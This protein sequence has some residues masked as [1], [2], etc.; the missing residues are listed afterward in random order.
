M[1]LMLVGGESAGLQALKAITRT[2]HQLVAVLASPSQSGFAGASVAGL[3]NRLG[4]PVWPAARVRD[5]EFGA[6]IRDAAVDLILNVH[7]LYLVHPEVLHAPRVGCF[8]LHPGPLPD[9]A[10]L[11]SPSWAIHNG[12]RSHGVT[13]HWMMKGIDVGPI[14]FQQRFPIED[15]DTGLSL[16][17]K[18]VRAGIPLIQELLRVAAT[19][20]GAI[21][22]LAQDLGKRRYFGAAPP[23]GGRLSWALPALQVFNLVRASDYRPF[24]SPWGYP[25]AD[26]GG[27]ELGIVSARRTGRP[28]SASPGTMGRSTPD[29]VEVACADEWL[30]IDEVAE[31][32]RCM[33]ASAVVEPLLGGCMGGDATVASLQ[34]EG[35]PAPMHEDVC[36]SSV[37]RS[38]EPR[39]S[40]LRSTRP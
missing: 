13:L 24:V 14:A 4:V 12:E 11:N 6:V 19:E 27:L 22:R 9:Y 25:R 35:W 38:V 3:A 17:L 5:P 29:G 16:A 34:P 36:A 7:S 37:T 32:G 18:C 23:D 28:T 33:K 21:P 26:L 2:S 40:P 8:N 39:H 15:A 31:D 30:L 20:P 1:N 10:G